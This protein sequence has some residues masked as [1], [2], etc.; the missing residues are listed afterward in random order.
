MLN[1]S[2]FH[3][4]QLTSTR[5]VALCALLLITAL[6]VLKASAPRSHAAGSK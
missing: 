1:L 3:H 4:R 6:V 2:L 5:V